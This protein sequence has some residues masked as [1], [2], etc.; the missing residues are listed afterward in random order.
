VSA[1]PEFAVELPIFSGPFR[2][3]ADLIL[4]RSVDVCDVPV[5]KVTE[6]FVRTGTEAAMAWSLEDA[7]WFLAICAVLLELKVGRLLPRHAVESEEDLL[8]GASPDL[9]YA[10][11]LEL[12]AFRRIASVLADRVAEASLLVARSAGAPPELAHLYPDIMEKVTA[13]DL[14]RMAEVLFEPEP[15]VD[16]S[17]VTPIRTSLAEAMDAVRAHL[18][19]RPE[20]RFRELVQECAERIDVVV[21]FLAILE[22]YRRGHVELSQAAMFGDIE[23]RWHG[24]G[25]AVP[26]DD[27]EEYG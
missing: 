3:L 24:G 12:Q 11:S 7:T 23:V 4:D 2:L 27:L 13:E 6:V 1:G 22:L 8:G 9:V 26:T 5:A 10:R 14:R 18:V 25:D 21:R 17:H 16:L 20:A 15:E 19:A